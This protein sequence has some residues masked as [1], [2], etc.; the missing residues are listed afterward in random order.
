MK[1][2]VRKIVVGF[3][4]GMTFG[5]LVGLAKKPEPVT[6]VE[7][8]RVGIIGYFDEEN[9]EWRDAYLFSDGSVRVK[10]GE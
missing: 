1:N 4:A 10:E 8:K 9:W 3:L 7:V 6:V 2:L 5:A